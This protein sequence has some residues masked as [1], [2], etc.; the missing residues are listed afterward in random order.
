MMEWLSTIL[1]SYPKAVRTVGK[2]LMSFA[3]SLGGFGWY[4]H[5]ILGRLD[6]RLSRLGAEGPQSLSEMYP[7]LPTWFIPETAFGFSLMVFL[8]VVGAALVYAG[9]QAARAMR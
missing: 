1:F 2:G 9:K 4:M 8:F 5:R 7:T 3:I 6:R